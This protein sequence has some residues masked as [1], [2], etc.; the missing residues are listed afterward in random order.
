[1]SAFLFTRGRIHH[2]PRGMMGGMDGNFTSDAH[3]E[4]ELI[5]KILLPLAAYVARA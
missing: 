1:M 4:M 5:L 2:R 3:L